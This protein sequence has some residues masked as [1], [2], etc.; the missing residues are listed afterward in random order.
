LRSKCDE[1]KGSEVVGHRL[2]TL[3]I[4][5]SQNITETWSREFGKSPS[6]PCSPNSPARTLARNRPPARAPVHVPRARSRSLLQR[7]CARKPL[8]HALADPFPSSKSLK[9]R[10]SACLLTRTHRDDARAAAACAQRS[11]QSFAVRQREFCSRFCR[12]W[13][14]RPAFSQVPTGWVPASGGATPGHVHRRLRHRRL[15]AA[16]AS[17]PCEA[18]NVRFT[19]VHTSV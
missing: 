3:Q 18:L 16:V 2:V 7:Q 11:H 19:P 8:A 17:S 10:A 6:C 9:L 12:G 1:K 14:E 4:A 15:L 13:H 5:K